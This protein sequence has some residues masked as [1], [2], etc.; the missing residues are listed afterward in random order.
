M[1][2]VRESSDGQI[3]TIMAGSEIGAIKVYL[4]KY[5]PRVGEVLSV[6]ERGRGDWETYDI[7]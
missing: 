3:R 5:R 7:R 1:Y 6:K 4:Q 2:F